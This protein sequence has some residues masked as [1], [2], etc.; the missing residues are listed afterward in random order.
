VKDVPI[1]IAE[2]FAMEFAGEKKGF[3][4]KQIT[5]FFSRYSN[6]VKPYEHYGIKLKR[7]E[8]FIESLYKLL[9]KEQYYALTR[10]CRQP[11]LMKNEVPPEEL[12]KNLFCELHSFHNVTPI[13]LMFSEL[14]EHTFRQEWF[15]AYNRL[16]SSPAS[17]ITSARTLLEKIFKT[18][19]TERNEIP[20]NPSELSKLFKQTI[21]VLN[22]K[23]AS[24]Q[25]EYR[26]LSGLTNIIYGVSGLSNASG[27]RHALVGNLE[28]DDPEIATLVLNASGT[29]G[30]FLIHLHLITPLPEIREVSETET[31]VVSSP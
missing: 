9:P 31:Q 20:A 25:E 3:S 10:L 28:I 5:D 16:I 11:P 6:M 23:K 12:R 17:A 26:I 14:E 18:I 29:V 7:S 19:I 30:L 8:L 15:K 1:E 13:G 27:D 4:G 21:D 2:K 24:R 22:F